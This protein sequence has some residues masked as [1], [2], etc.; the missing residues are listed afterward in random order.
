ME[1]TVSRY[2]RF[3]LADGKAVLLVADNFKEAV[4]RISK[5]TSANVIGVTS[6]QV[7]LCKYDKVDDWNRTVK[8]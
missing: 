5:K 3:A 2:F 1:T 7:T 8:D 4:S 6:Y